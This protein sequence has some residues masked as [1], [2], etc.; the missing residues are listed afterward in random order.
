MKHK[1]ILLIQHTLKHTK[2]ESQS[3]TFVSEMKSLMLGR[4]SLDKS[5]RWVTTPAWGTTITG[6]TTYRGGLWGR[7]GISSLDLLAG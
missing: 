2:I 5:I 4:K 7:M 6:I 1:W 3:L